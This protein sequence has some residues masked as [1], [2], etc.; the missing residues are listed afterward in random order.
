MALHLRGVQRKDGSGGSLA[1]GEILDS[2]GEEVYLDLIQYWGVDLTEFIAG[3]VR[4]SVKLILLK[5]NNLPEGARYPAAVVYDHPPEPEE[6]GAPKVPED[7]R[8]KA[9]HD[10]RL[11]TSDRRLMATA[12]NAIFSN[13]AVSGTWKDNKP[14]KFPTVG[15][16]EWQPAEQKAVTSSTKSAEP[17]DLYEVL[18]KMGWPGG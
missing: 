17:K 14:P 15:P 5:L 9:I 10:A 11:W 6:P 16:P 4:T 18:G 12:I 3:E 2:Y 7:P 1:L 13:T 8:M